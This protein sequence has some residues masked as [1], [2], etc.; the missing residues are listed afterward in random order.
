MKLV[1]LASI[2][3]DRSIPIKNLSAPRLNELQIALT[4]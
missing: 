3:P 2:R 1:K 4:D